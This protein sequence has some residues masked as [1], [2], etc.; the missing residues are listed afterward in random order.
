[1]FS[2]FTAKNETLK[3]VCEKNQVGLI[4]C[5]L[6]PG[7][8]FTLGILLKDILTLPCYYIRECWAKICISYVYGI[9]KLRYKLD[10]RSAN[11]KESV[12][13]E[14]HGQIEQNA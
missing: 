6:A 10:I 12:N 9:T 1:M 11:R 3:E 14:P 4:W 7:I 5:N 8:E 2:N 13:S